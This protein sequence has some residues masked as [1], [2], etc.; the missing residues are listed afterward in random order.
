MKKQKNKS[1]S[2]RHRLKQINSNFKS[3]KGETFIFWIF[4]VLIMTFFG[5]FSTASKAPVL[6]NE[7]SKAVDTG[8]NF[9]QLNSVEYEGI[10]S[11]GGLM[12]RGNDA[13]FD[14]GQ[15]DVLILAFQ[16]PNMLVSA[17]GFDTASHVQKKEEYASR[18]E[19]NQMAMPIGQLLTNDSLLS[20]SK[21]ADMEGLGLS[22]DRRLSS[23][24]NCHL[25]A[26]EN[27]IMISWLQA[28]LF[29]E[30]GIAA[31]EGSFMPS[32]VDQLVGKSVKGKT[33]VGIYENKERN[34]IESVFPDVF[35][36]E[37]KDRLQEIRNGVILSSHA[38]T[39]TG[40]TIEGKSTIYGF[41]TNARQVATC[42][43]YLDM[44]NAYG[45]GRIIESK[46]AFT[47]NGYAIDIFREY[48]Q[49]PGRYV[50]I[51]LLLFAAWAILAFGK[52]QVK[53]TKRIQ[54][55]PSNDDVLKTSLLQGFLMA[56]CIAVPSWLL[57]ALACVIFNSV[58]HASLLSLSLVTSLEIFLFVLAV[59]CLSIP[60][61]FIGIRRDERKGKKQELKKLK[62]LTTN[63]S[64]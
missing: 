57:V 5:C 33:I 9:I 47:H 26:S 34:Y 18:F 55:T 19:E 49:E 58:V 25:P 54:P 13:P 37:R 44:R 11:Q 3:S 6:Y 41:V 36:T 63:L 1:I 12:L 61:G 27:E 17:G 52:D 31:D 20:I 40:E 50:V 48:V 15:K 56:I 42:L 51:V 14:E 24:T 28:D 16:E 2:F 30:Y 60:L 64:D 7:F 46:N 59:L 62:R 21:Y 38:L 39:Y 29:L 10:L 4:S 45:A 23:A 8:M 35:S 32:S 22:F 53:L 43:E